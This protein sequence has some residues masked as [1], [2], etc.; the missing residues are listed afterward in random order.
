[1]KRRKRKRRVSERPES[2]G[3]SNVTSPK[4]KNKKPKL[5]RGKLNTVAREKLNTRGQSKAKQESQHCKLE[6][7]MQTKKNTKKKN[8]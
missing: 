5:K 8:A 1:M 7:N 4:N 3:S 2:Q 6:L